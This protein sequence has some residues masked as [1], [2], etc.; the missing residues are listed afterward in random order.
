MSSLSHHNYME[1]KPKWRY[2]DPCIKQGDCSGRSDQGIGGRFPGKDSIK[3]QTNKQIFS[4]KLNFAK[5]ISPII[6]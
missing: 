6:P 5:K 3:I 4:I 2:L 1:E